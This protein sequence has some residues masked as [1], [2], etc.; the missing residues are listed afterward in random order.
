M[1]SLAWRARLGAMTE[2]IRSSPMAMLW[3][4][5]ETPTRRRTFWST[6][7]VKTARTTPGIVPRPPLMSTPPS[8][9]IVTTVSVE[10]GAVVGAGA[11]EA[12]GQ[13]DAGERRDEPGQHEQQQILSAAHVDARV[14]GGLPVLA[15]GEDL[16]ADPG[17]VEDDA[18]DAPPG[19]RRRPASTG[20]A[21]PARSRSPN[22]V[23]TS[24]KSLMPRG[25]RTTQREAAEERERAEG[26]DE[27]RQ[28]RRAST[29]TPLSSPPSAPTTST[30]GMP[31]VERHAGGP[32]GSRGP[33]STGPSIDSTDRS[34][35]PVMMISVIGSAMIATSIT[36][37]VEVR[38]VR[39]DRKTGDARPDPR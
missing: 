2:T 17:A 25:P 13:D 30:A 21:C 7:R 10:P 14:A 31:S 33:R 35:S 38:E 8:R 15:D 1:A 22:V 5:L 6:A 28:A 4:S 11:R 29:S 27:R 34:I 19:P 3:Y 26:D 16:A 18:E 24:G 39:A 9:T 23:N 12:R 36:A 32:A 20:S 37:L